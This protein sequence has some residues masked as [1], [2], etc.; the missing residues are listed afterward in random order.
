MDLGI[1]GKVAIVTGAGQGIGHDTAL[2]LAAE[3]VKVCVNDIDGKLGKE[4]AEEICRAGGEA[5]YVH[6]D[7]GVEADIRELF[8]TVA[9]ELGTVDILV[10]N[11]AV[12]PKVPFEEIPA[13][14]F[15]EVL[16]VN[17]LGALLCSQQAFSQMKEKR[18]GR[19]ISLSSMA[20][21]FGA[22]KAGVHYAASKA[23]IIGMTLS[24]AK[25]MGPYNITVNCVAPGR[26]N[27]ALTKVLPQKVQEEI[28]GQ[29]PLGRIGEPWE[30]ASVIT[31]LAS[32]KAGYVSGACVDVLGGYIA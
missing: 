8:A 24:L 10:N 21:K 5:I 11:A 4:T 12:S 25:R 9:R 6:G 20:G 22:N 26:I 13:E 30:V 32:E 18:W 29:I 28:R 16:R 17:L 2:A 14:Q 27:T 15:E 31:F 7:V 19:I 3:G 1:S 23:G